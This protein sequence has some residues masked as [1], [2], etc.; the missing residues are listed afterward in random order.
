MK[1]F[2][3]TKTAIL[4]LLLL[5]NVMESQAT[6]DSSVGGGALTKV[7]DVS[8]PGPAVRFDYQSLDPNHGRLYIA[9]LNADQLSS[10]ILTSGR[11]SRT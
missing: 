9:H 6:K 5:P 11:L 7:A 8:M 1:S 2:T 3:S 4:F 10:S